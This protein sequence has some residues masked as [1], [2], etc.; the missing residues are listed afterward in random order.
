[1]K[2]DTSK[3]GNWAVEILETLDSHAEDMDFP[4]FENSNFPAVDMRLT[5]FRDD[6][7]WLFAFEVIAFA[8]SQ[9]LFVNLIYTYGNQLSKQGMQFVHEIKSVEN[10]NISQDTEE[11]FV[12]K[13]SFGSSFDGQVKDFVFS[14]NDYEIAGVDLTCGD[15]IELLLL[16]L[17]T[18]VASHDLFLSSDVLLKT[19]G[20]EEIAE[21]MKLED[22]EH[23]DILNDE[24]PSQ[25]EC[26][27][28]LAKALMHN[29]RELYFC[30]SDKINTHWSFWEY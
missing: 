1:M 25:S 29:E 16:K 13:F 17:L 15:P 26:F 9:N 11:Q 7:E 12:S 20:K 30:P 28:S 22:W 3:S 23:P 19:L 4:T 10:L 8:N 21:F 18:S 2:S 5:V 6:K 24:L 14:R 27:K